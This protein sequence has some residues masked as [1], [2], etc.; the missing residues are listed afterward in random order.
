MLCFSYNTFM[1]TIPHTKHI[2]TAEQLLNRPDDGFRYELING[3]LQQMA[4]AGF[5]HGKISAI[6]TTSLG[7]Y[8]AAQKLGVVCAAETGFKLAAN[9][10]YVRAPD[11]AFIS[12]QQ[13]AQHQNIKGYWP[14]APAL[15]VEV[16][17][18]YDT[19]TDVEEKVLDWLEAGCK[20]VI[21][22]NPRKQIAT[23]YRTMGDIC[24]IGKGGILQATDIVPG[25]Q[26]PID[27]LFV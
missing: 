27:N 5:E 23:L 18:P 26:L 15:V 14:G 19:Y 22:I 2:Y 7:H 21:V 13:L 11:M 12:N 3:E 20:L 24:M 8:V 1:Q 16:I 9:P 10:D 6:V 4:P 17:S 25:W